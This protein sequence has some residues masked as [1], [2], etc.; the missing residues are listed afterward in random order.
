MRDN[1]SGQVKQDATP[2]SPRRFYNEKGCLNQMLPGCGNMS[3][4]KDIKA[5]HTCFA[6][7]SSYQTFISQSDQ[8]CQASTNLR[9]LLIGH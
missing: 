5:S 9:F 4:N 7:S 1:E 6:V 3:L 2:L 8:I